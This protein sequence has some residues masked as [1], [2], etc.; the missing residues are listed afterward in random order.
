MDSFQTIKEILFNKEDFFLITVSQFGASV[1]HFKI[2]LSNGIY[3]VSHK[4]E[5]S[6]RFIRHRFEFKS[7]SSNLKHVEKN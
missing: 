3:S 1:D 2:C 4:T 7:Q 5:I 6:E